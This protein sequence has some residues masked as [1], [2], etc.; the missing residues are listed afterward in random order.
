MPISRHPQSRAF[1]RT[2]LGVAISLLGFGMVLGGVA[3]TTGLTDG[4]ASMQN[5]SVS[6]FSNGNGA[7][8]SNG[9][10][11]QNGGATTSSG[12]GSEAMPIVN[13]LSGNG[14]QDS[15]NTDTGETVDANG[16]PLSVDQLPAL[17]PCA[18]PGPRMIRRLTGPQFQNTLN[19][20]FGA[21]DVPTAQVLTD[22]QVNGFKVDADAPVINGLDA[23]LLMN[24]SEMVADWAVT[25]NHLSGFTNGC[26]QMN[27]QCQ[28]QFIKN[29]GTAISRDTISQDR[30]SAYQTIFAGEDNFAD[31]ERAVV[32]AMLQSP[33]LMYRRELGQQNGNTWQLTQSEIASELSY[34][35]TNNPPDKQL[36]Q[37]AQN[38]QLSSKD[39]IDQ[40]VARL[41]TTDAG[42]AQL[43]QFMQSWLDVDDLPGKAKSDAVPFP[44]SVRQE[45]L[46]ETRL[47]F[48]DVFSSGGD[49]TDLLTANYGYV[50]QELATFYGIQGVTG[51]AMQKVS[52]DG[53]HRLPGVLGEGSFLAKHAQPENS[54]PVQ[55]AHVVRERFLCDQ[56]PPV[57]TN[58][59]TNLKPPDPNSTNRERYHNHDSNPVCY[60][61]H[62][63]MDPIG[64]TFE[65]YDGFGLY[66]TTEAGQTVDDT[67]NYMLM[68]EGTNVPLDGPQTL[69]DYLSQVE[70]TRACMIRY[71]S[72]FSYGRANWDNKQ[73]SDDTI[74]QEA[75]NNNNT[76]PSV[77]SAIVHAPQ[78]TQ[79]VKDPDA[80]A[81]Q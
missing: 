63:L 16:M 67:G 48:N 19:Q 23:E 64:F 59:D 5:P 69:I 21:S 26:E 30:V 61:C 50:N 41:I 3:C 27:D 71:W 55:R 51:D 70:D 31:G 58:L 18:T 14:L 52:F 39:Q 34:M 56:L 73:C 33:F 49:V 78:F 35:I 62:Q 9:N 20:I 28:Q 75:R 1:G 65:N 37:A 53:T 10:S 60:S 15:S 76:L 47:L 80:T 17:A 46:Q 12:G 22:P 68:P 36:Q 6:P 72:Y 25:N 43:G 2:G 81:S 7:P 40:Q 13:G 42:K 38:N 57:P 79:R 8:G 29:F 74:R 44:D 45:M 32:S 11:A 66:R 54:S 4:N 24:Y 77:L